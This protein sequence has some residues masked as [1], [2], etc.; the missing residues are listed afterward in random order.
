M[1]CKTVRDGSECSFMTAQGCSYKG[2]SC[3]QIIEQCEECK[4]TVELSSGWYCTAC[5][6]PELKW[7]VGNCN[8]ATHVSREVAETKA[9]INPLKA[10]KR[11]G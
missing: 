10:S 11:K 7:K 8:L 1:I 5:P 6:D 3:R 4:R 9:K 2:G